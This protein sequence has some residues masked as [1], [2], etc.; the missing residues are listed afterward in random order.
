MATLIDKSKVGCIPVVWGCS[1]CDA[2][3]PTPFTGSTTEEKGAL[4]IE[5]FNQH[6]AKAH[7]QPLPRESAN[8]QRG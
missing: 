4:L 8:E 6:V 5:E 1:E 2:V 3:F 7:K